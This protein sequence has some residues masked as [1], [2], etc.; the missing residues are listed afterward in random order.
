VPFFNPGTAPGVCLLP[1]RSGSN[2]TQRRT[3]VI[4]GGRL[5]SMSNRCFQHCRMKHRSVLR[6]KPLVRS[7][8]SPVVV[9]NGHFGPVSR[10]GVSTVLTVIE[11]DEV[12]VPE[13]MP[14]TRK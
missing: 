8:I 9:Q 4:D 1:C 11:I 2:A 14:P 13:M 10:E 3:I 5:K 6:R 7:R 12:S